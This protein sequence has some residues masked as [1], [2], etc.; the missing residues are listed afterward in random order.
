MAIEI[1][2]DQAPHWLDRGGALKE[3]DRREEANAS[4]AKAFGKVK[5]WAS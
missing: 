3:L 5:L 2:P 1:D 4:F